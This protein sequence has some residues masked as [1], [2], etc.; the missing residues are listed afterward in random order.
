M[1]NLPSVFDS[2]WEFLAIPLI[3]FFVVL[4][5]LYYFSDK[6]LF[7]GWIGNWRSQIKN[8][9]SKLKGNLI[10]PLGMST[11]T[12]V[13]LAIAVIVTIAGI[14]RIAHT[15]GDVIPGS[16]MTHEERAMAT[17]ANREDLSEIWS[18]K[19]KINEFDEL[20]QYILHIHYKQLHSFPDLA[21]AYKGQFDSVGAMWSNRSFYK[22]LILYLFMVQ[23]MVMAILGIRA[24]NYFSKLLVVMLILG[25]CLV[26]NFKEQYDFIR[27]TT[28]LQTRNVRIMLEPEII[29]ADK[30]YLDEY[31]KKIEAY[32]DRQPEK[33][34]VFF[35]STIDHIWEFKD[36]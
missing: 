34:I 16:L 7:K 12:S 2:I 6:M 3:E 23:P 18:T 36:L 11:L 17:F 24:K 14:S 25:V 27:T 31:R 20:Y 1:E 30:T 9:Y 28:F 29:N 32:L 19:P 21:V 22:F 33:P 5:F 35:P 10:I 26:Y 8:Y 4:F 13:T 15:I